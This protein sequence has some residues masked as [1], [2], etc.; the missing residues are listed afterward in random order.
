MTNEQDSG[1]TTPL[2]SPLSILCADDEPAIRM[3]IQAFMEDMGYTVQTAVNGKEA[4]RLIEAADFDAVLLDLAMPELSGL[5]V[6]KQTSISH[7][8][9]PV[10]VI[11]GT[12]NIKD[13]IQALRLGA[14]DFITKPVEDMAIVLHALDRTVE[15]ARLIKENTLHRERLQVLVDER[16]RAL[17]EE[18]EQRKA[19]EEALRA[20]LNEKEV[21]LKE[22]HHRVKNNLQIV[23]SLLSLQAM[24]FGDELAAPFL[25]SQARVRAMAL[26]HEKLYRAGDLS[27]IDF[28]SYISDLTGFLIQ[29]YTARGACIR[30]S[31][32][33]RNF[34]LGVDTAIPCGL[35]VN[36]LVTNCLKHAFKGL[37]QGNIAITLVMND[38]MARLELSDDGAGL[39]KDFC[40][41]KVESLGLQLVMNLT[42]QLKGSFCY[43]RLIQGV[44]F[45]LCFPV[46]AQPRKD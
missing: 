1:N 45:V 6:L 18:I 29:A 17:T 39:P 34:T 44:R 40:L 37:D 9:L 19:I 23:S 46:P 27:R 20:S 21:L 10:V 13:V 14:W 42:R 11:S 24:R 28:A 43:E 22:V 38:G 36:E 30:C 26:V 12:G 35:A 7:P 16:T 41:E 2:T 33:V 31:V 5:D 15:R 25:D 8:E 4:L 32:D 3:T